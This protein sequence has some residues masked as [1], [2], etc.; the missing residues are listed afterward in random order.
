MGLVL[1]AQAMMQLP[2][3]TSLSV[4][5]FSIPYGESWEYAEQRMHSVAEQHR[6]PIELD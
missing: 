4:F 1:L 3:L 2:N 6:P 5:E